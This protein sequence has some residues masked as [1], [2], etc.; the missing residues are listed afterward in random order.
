MKR[1][2]V[3]SGAHCLIQRIR[4]GYVICD[5]CREAVARG[6]GDMRDIE[7]GVYTK[8]LCRDMDQEARQGH[9]NCTG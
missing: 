3:R 4:V 5:I 6:R 2:E 7:A 1:C 8:D 9:D